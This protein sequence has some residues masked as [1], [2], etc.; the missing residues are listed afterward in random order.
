MGPKTALA[1]APQGMRFG[2]HSKRYRIFC[3]AY[4]K[5][6]RPNR[7]GEVA[8]RPIPSSFPFYFHASG[9]SRCCRKNS[10]FRQRVQWAAP[11]VAFHRLSQICPFLCHFPALQTRQSEKLSNFAA[12]PTIIP[13]PI[14]QEIAP[15][16]FVVERGMPLSTANR[17]GLVVRRHWLR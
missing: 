10:R 16:A 15:T 17:V 3:N 12:E 14:C 9:R 5:F 6:C 11:G 2:H 4:R 13:P 8:F 7:G 1:A